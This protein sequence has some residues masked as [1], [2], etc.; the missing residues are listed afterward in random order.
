MIVIDLMGEAAAEEAQESA[1]V[2]ICVV[3]CQM[4]W[5]K[6]RRVYLISEGLINNCIEAT[7]LCPRF[8]NAALRFVVLGAS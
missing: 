3:A 2:W 1:R 4:C 6:T 8:Q 7:A 5:E